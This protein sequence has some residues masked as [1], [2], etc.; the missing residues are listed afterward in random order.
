M[1]MENRVFCEDAIIYDTKLGD[2]VI[3][4]CDVT[5]HNLE[6]VGH[7]E[8][9]NGGRLYA[10]KLLYKDNHKLVVNE[11]EQMLDDTEEMVSKVHSKYGDIGINT[12]VSH[13]A[14]D[15]MVEMATSKDT[16]LDD[17]KARGVDS[18]HIFDNNDNRIGGYQLYCKENYL[19]KI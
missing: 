18:I 6:S 12:Q 16:L 3:D 14:F 1:D 17:L 4:G 15:K 8:L 9:R 10:V 19:Q 13:E 5:A 7:I 2:I 11:Y